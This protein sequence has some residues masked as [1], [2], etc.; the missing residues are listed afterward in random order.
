MI[1]DYKVKI[2]PVI[3]QKY[4]QMKTMFDQDMPVYMKMMAYTMVNYVLSVI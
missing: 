3:I 4:P 1:N 2:A